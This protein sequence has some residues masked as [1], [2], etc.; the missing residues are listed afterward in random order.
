MPKEEFQ[1]RKTEAKIMTYDT[2]LQQELEVA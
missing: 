1:K 2:L